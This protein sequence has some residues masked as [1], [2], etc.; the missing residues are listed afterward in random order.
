[1]NFQTDNV[2]WTENLEKFLKI[3]GE[4]SLCLSILHKDSE[5]LYSYKAMRI[6]LPVIVFSTLCGS[7]TLSAKNIFGEENENDALKFVGSLSLI[8][9]ILGTVQSYFGY[10]RCAEN[11]RISYLQYSKLYRFI[12]IQLGLP[13][14]QRILPKDLLKIVAENFERLN[15]ISN[16]I[17]ESI[18]AKFRTKYKK[19]TIHR[20]SVVN[21]LEQIEIYRPNKELVKQVEN[22]R[23]INEIH[24]DLEI[25]QALSQLNSN[26]PMQ[27][28]II[29]NVLSK[30]P[31][32]SE[33]EN[34]LESIKEENEDSDL[35]LNELNV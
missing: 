32:K 20:P 4:H 28:D 27:K 17:P 10:N 23:Y 26:K 15:E 19:E 24:D 5:A 21:G 3:L 29:S 6:D 2:Q 25:Q 30:K 7:L 9:G 16:L 12:K 18:A 22:D 31:L 33:K 34:A 13:R 1:M 35:N 14:E 8:T 11:H